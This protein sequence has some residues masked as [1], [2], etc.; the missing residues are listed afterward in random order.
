M[1]TAASAKE[2]SLV[3]SKGTILPEGPEVRREAQRLQRVLLNAKL[4]ELSIVSGRY[5]RSPI[6]GSE[7][8]PGTRVQD[9][10]SHGK[11]I[12]IA[13]ESQEGPVYIHS[14]LGMTGW[15]SQ[16][17]SKY[18][19]FALLGDKSISFHD[20]RNFGTIKVVNQA[21][22]SKKLKSLGPDFSRVSL[23]N[24]NKVKTETSDRVRRYGSKQTI[25]QALLDQRIFCGIG[26]YLRADA[27]YLAGISPHLNARSLPQDR[28]DTLIFN[29]GIVTMAAYEDVSPVGL[30]RPY[31]HVAY[32]R[33]KSLRG[34]SMLAEQVDGRT[35]WWCPAE[36]T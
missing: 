29:C 12:H 2:Q 31:H 4:T 3:G 19:R 35:I 22:H 8:V 23:D 36:Q 30:K 33:S 5:T 24:I 28:L 16:E 14:T 17:K 10:S 32:H 25:G 20:P 27:L 21:E 34:N 15:W 11:L 9:V 6:T 18:I 1:T 13:L 26:N 7:L